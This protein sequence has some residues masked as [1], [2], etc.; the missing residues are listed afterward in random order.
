MSL[1]NL[2]R[3]Q[4]NS[5]NQ[6]AYKIVRDYTA[7]HQNAF[8]DMVDRALQGV[9]ASRDTEMCSLLGQWLERP[10]RDDYVDLT[11]L[12]RLCGSEA[13]QPVPV[14]LRPP[15]D[16]LWQRDPFQV[17]GGSGGTVESAGIDY[18]LP[19]WMGRY[20]G[21]ISADSAVSK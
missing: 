7:S 10:A 11:H 8:F 13:C 19:Y 1:Y 2:I 18:I 16:Y 15:T 4:N 6:R 9:N 5:H 21:V 17:A 3:L 12:L 14:S 20:F